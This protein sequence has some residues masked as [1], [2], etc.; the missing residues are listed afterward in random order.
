MMRELDLALIF[1]MKPEIDEFL[2]KERVEYQ[3]RCAQT[4][5]LWNQYSKKRVEFQDISKA[6]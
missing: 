2:S 1:L 4:R 3:K 6:E 5:E